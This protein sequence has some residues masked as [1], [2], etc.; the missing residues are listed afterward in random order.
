MA[1]NVENLVI[2]HLR[3]IR[4]RVD[5]IADDMSDLKRR[6]SSLETSMVLVKR[7]VAASD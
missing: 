6:M 3:H 5:Q 2:E 4:S 1:E 7:E